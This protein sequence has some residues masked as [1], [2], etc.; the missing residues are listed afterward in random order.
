[1]IV[2]RV[3]RVAAAACLLSAAG[4]GAQ[5]LSEVR[6]PAELPPP[7]YTGK[8][9]VDSEG[10]VFVRAGMG[11]QVDWVPRV[12]RQ[13][14]ILCGYAPT[15]P[16]RVAEPAA[17]A[18]AA[19]IS[20]AP[21]AA[22]PARVA[23][24]APSSVLPAAVPPQPV[25]PADLARAERGPSVTRARAVSQ[26]PA[27][28]TAPAVI[29]EGYQSAYAPGRLNPWRGIG[30]PEGEA[31]MNRRWTQTL[32]RREISEPRQRVVAVHPATQVY[33]STRNAVE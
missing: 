30:T 9:Y 25:H 19:P 20:A 5:S 26:S 1:M 12:D 24:S 7:G 22:A 13:R 4:A 32:P 8:Q 17:K 23:S 2:G 27:G 29:P 3:F 15:L 11:G 31:A 33:R 28:G 18:P 14:R 16:R 6:S 10:C 21:R